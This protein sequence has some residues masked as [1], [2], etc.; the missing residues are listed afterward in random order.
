MQENNLDFSYRNTRKKSVCQLNSWLILY[1]TGQS[2]A[3]NQVWTWNKYR[4]VTRGKFYFKGWS[5]EGNSYSVIT[6]CAQL[7][8]VQLRSSSPPNSTLPGSLW[9]PWEQKSADI[10]MQ[11]C[12]FCHLLLCNLLGSKETRVLLKWPSQLFPSF[13]LFTLPTPCFFQ[14]RGGQRGVEKSEVC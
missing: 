1:P 10:M 6:M 2:F 7:N 8:A 3:Q 4:I 11:L 5:P 9:H 13:T 14:K 12:Q